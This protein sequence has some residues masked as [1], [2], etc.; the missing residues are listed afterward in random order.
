MPFL[1]VVSWRKPRE[2]LTGLSQVRVQAGELFAALQTSR[3][4]LTTPA[5]V[6][7]PVRLHLDIN[8]RMANVMGVTSLPLCRHSKGLFDQYAV[9]V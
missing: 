3:S 2:G 6:R 5:A 9:R 7:C 4:Q 1:S 8:N